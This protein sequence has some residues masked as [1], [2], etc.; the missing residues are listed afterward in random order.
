MLFAMRPT[1]CWRL[2][3]GLAHSRCYVSSLVPGVAVAL[4]KCDVGKV[5]VSL[6]TVQVPLQEVCRPSLWVP[7]AC[8]GLSMS[9]RPGAAG[10]QSR[11]GLGEAGAPCW[12]HPLS[13]RGLC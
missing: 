7:A 3:V 13:G 8:L 12:A 6:W 2:V 4:W 9:G 5:P 11:V 1:C 10:G